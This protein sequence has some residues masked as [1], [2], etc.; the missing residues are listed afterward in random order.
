[1]S[2][3]LTAKVSTS[4]VTTKTPTGADAGNP[5]VGFTSGNPSGD[6]YT[7]STSVTV[8]KSAK[9]TIA[10]DPTTHTLDLTAIPDDINGTIDGTGLKVAF[11]RFEATSTNANTLGFA[12]GASNGY[13]LNATTTAWSDSLVAGQVWQRELNGAGDTIGSTHKSIDF[14]GT[15]VQTIKCHIVLSA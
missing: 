11:L 9:F 7:P 15:G 14:S 5:D 4:I 6:S 12:N 1:M 3:T 13:R 2:Y 8:S 10:L